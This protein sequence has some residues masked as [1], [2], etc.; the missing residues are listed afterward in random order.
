MAR[1]A[2]AQG[3]QFVGKLPELVIGP[4]DVRRLARELESINDV[5]ADR[6][7]RQK[8]DSA[9]MLKA[10]LLLEQT[11]ALNKLNLLQKKDRVLLAQFLQIV[12]TKAPVLHMS[13]SADPSS[14]FLAKL[15]AWLRQEIHPYALLN[16][17]LQPTIG[18]GCILRTT[19]K[20]FDFS[21]RQHFAKQR[22]LLLEQLIPPTRKVET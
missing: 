22:M 17:G 15:M 3:P 9:K 14:A 7:L 1:E 10:S 2:E 20:Y 8:G 16:V 4:A 19:N 11:V 12:Q 21:L 13:F 5:M 18:A 6:R